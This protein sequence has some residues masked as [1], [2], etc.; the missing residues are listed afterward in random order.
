MNKGLGIQ[1][2]NAVRSEEKTCVKG[3]NG[4]LFSQTFVN[5]PPI[6]RDFFGTRK[7]TFPAS[8]TTLTDVFPTQQ[9]KAYNFGFSV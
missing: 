2:N 5:F 1:K 3:S 8:A 4:L 6:F 9:G 7:T